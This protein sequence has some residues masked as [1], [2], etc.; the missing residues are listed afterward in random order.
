MHELSRVKGMEKL[1]V[2]LDKEKE[3]HVSINP[4]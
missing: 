1:M 3:S 2:E 4:N